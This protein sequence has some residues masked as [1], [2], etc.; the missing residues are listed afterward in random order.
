MR[1]EEATHFACDM[2]WLPTEGLH[3]CSSL[4]PE[5]PY[6]GRV[7]TFQPILS[8]RINAWSYGLLS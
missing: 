6:L 2:A 1:S 8:K 4:M 5:E 7:G 3:P